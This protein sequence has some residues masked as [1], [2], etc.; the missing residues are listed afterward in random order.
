ME[1]VYTKLPY[2]SDVPLK[3]PRGKR[4]ADITFVIDPGHGG[5]D[6][7]AVGPTGV[8]E[9]DVN[10]ALALEVTRLL[11]LRGYHVEM[12]RDDDSFPALYDRPKLAHCSGADAFVSIHHNAPP[13]GKD[14]NEVRY[15]AVYAWNE[16]G[17]ALA[18][19]VNR[20]M[21]IALRNLVDDEGVLHANFAVTRNPEI[22]SC[23]IEADFISHPQGERECSDPTRQRLVA[24][25][26]A[27]G[28]EDWL[29]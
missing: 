7:G 26:I 23:L 22:P 29:K 8:F 19:A 15:H 5:E 28:L 9:K 10:L 24:K 1:R 16:I 13:P 27:D 25:A 14:P 4:A 2:A 12:T 11:R 17:E 18:T 3:H 20:R 6:K 21:V